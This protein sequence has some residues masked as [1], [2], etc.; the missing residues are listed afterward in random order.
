[1]IHTRHG[2]TGPES[3][4]SLWLRW[5]PVWLRDCR[6]FTLASGQDICAPRLSRR[7]LQILSAWRYALHIYN[8]PFELQLAS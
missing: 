3:G 7:L 8:F 4:S 2:H 5:W 6:R 1:M